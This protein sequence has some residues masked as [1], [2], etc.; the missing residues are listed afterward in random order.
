MFKS[1]LNSS[2]E[3]LGTDSGGL[4]QILVPRLNRHIGISREGI[5]CITWS[6]DAN[7]KVMNFDVCK[8]HKKFQGIYLILSL[9]AF[10]ERSVLEELSTLAAFQADNMKLEAGT[11]VGM[12]GVDMDSIQKSRNEMKELATLVAR[13]T[14]SMSSDD[15]GGPSEYSEFFTTLR[16]VFGIPTKRAELREE[17][18]D[19]LALLESSYLEERRRL[20]V[21]EQREEKADRER[22][23]KIRLM[24]ESHKHKYDTMF[25]AISSLTIP[26]VLLSSLF[27]MNISGLPD[28]KFWQMLILIGVISLIALVVQLIC[29]KG[30]DKFEPLE[31]TL[32]LSPIEP[33][34]EKKG[35]W[36][37][38]SK[39]REKNNIHE[40]V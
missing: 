12:R 38:L 36:L 20:K 40:A 23:R 16:R 13:F 15:C 1:N 5:V 7:A 32:L 18:Q 25:S 37:H 31:E 29:F 2:N 30:M 39:K 11:G 9:H 4:D 27:G 22:I 3:T 6:T 33:K 14:I 28:I 19:T 24:K 35:S 10:G 26:A 21:E 17:L 34:S 8:W